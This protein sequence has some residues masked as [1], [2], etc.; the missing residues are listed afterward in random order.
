MSTT[1]KSDLSVTTTDHPNVGRLRLAFDAFSR[2]DLDTVRDSMTPDA[3]WTNAGSSAIGGTFEGWDAISTMFG[4][5]FVAT[6]GTFTINLLSVL[7]DDKHAVAVYDATATIMGDSQ[8]HRYVL[9]DDMTPDGKSK[10]T[11]V[12]AYD[13]AAADAHMPR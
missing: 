10:A 13:Q 8:T 11:H 5:L 7:A 3:V 12:L 2:G 1:T 9:V 6:D 4:K